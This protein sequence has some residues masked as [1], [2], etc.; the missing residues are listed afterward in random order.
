MRHPS[1]SAELDPYARATPQRSP[2]SFAFETMWC[3]LERNGLIPLRSAFRPEKASR[4]LAN[5]AL[6]EVD[7]GTPDKPGTPR[8]PMTTR[9]R[10]VGSAIRDLVDANLTGL[11][12]L[13]LVPDRAYQA[14]Y[15]DVCMNHPCA[16]WSASPV[17]Y[18]RGYNALVEITNFPLIDDVTGG[19]LVLVMILEMGTDTFKHRTIQTPVELR[20]AVAKSFIDI[21]A[22]L[23]DEID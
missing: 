15:L 3:G 1:K 14:E 5:I 19:H 18:G 23:P 21:G 22:G 4:L 8:T 6:L 12:Y 10:L 13:D 16:A 20:P 17:I 2:E 11:D 9:I 7:A